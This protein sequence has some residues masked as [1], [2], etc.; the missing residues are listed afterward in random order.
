MDFTG[1]IDKVIQVVNSYGLDNN[2]ATIRFKMVQS[3]P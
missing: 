1:N 2:D 3:I